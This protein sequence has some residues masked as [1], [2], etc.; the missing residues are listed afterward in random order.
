MDNGE[1]TME[2]GEL[3]MENEHLKIINQH[4]KFLSVIRRTL[5]LKIKLVCNAWYLRGI[6]I[7]LS[8]RITNPP[9]QLINADKI[10]LS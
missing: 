1:W 9:M 5:R 7:I 6:P 3:G 8:Q 4:Q 10:W 2:N